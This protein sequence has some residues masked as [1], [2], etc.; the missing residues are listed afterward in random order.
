VR[1]QKKAE[2]VLELLEESPSLCPLV[3]SVGEPFFL[4]SLLFF[5]SAQ[6][7]LA[8]NSFLRSCA[9]K[10]P[11]PTPREQHSSLA[12]ATARSGAPPM[13]H[14]LSSR[15]N[16][17]P[18]TR[19]RPPSRPTNLHR[20]IAGATRA[21]GRPITATTTGPDT[22]GSILTTRTTTDAISALNSD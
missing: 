1:S 4:F 7:P 10:P 12:S 11:S 21:S 15:S 8:Q 5:Q 18:S 2:A 3:Q 13:R 22:I 20:S 14:F 19:S 16:L 9:R 6:P 17:K